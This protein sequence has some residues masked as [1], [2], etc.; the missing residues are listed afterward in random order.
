MWRDILSIRELE[1]ILLAIGDVDPALI[2]N[3]ADISGR[4]PIVAHH[5]QRRF[6]VPIVPAHHV[7]SAHQ[8]FAV[9]G[10]RYFNAPEWLANRADAIVAGTIRTD[11][12]GFGHAI[13]L[14]DPDAG[15]EK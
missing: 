15:A 13:A 4:E 5:R 14:Q 8:H 9:I 6:R 7:R 11:D 2:V 1:Q 3:V 12:A 10:D